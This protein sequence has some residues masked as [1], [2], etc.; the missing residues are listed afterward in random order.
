MLTGF[1]TAT[2]GSLQS[3][4]SRTAPQFAAPGS[5]HDSFCSLV[6]ARPCGVGKRPAVLAGSLEA[7]RESETM[8]DELAQLQRLLTQVGECLEQRRQRQAIVVLRRVAAVADTLAR[9]LELRHAR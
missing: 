4:T 1:D 9:T 6:W 5:R 3:P 2:P 7:R 8:N